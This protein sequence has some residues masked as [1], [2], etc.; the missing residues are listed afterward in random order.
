MSTG[1]QRLP[2]D[3]AGLGPAAGLA[4]AALVA[5]CLWKAGEAGAQDAKIMAYGRHLAQ[6]CTGCHRID[7][8]DNGI[9]SITGWQADAFIAT[10]RFY[11]RGE[12]KNPVMVSVANSLNEKQLEA[13]AT[14][15]GSLPKPAPKGKRPGR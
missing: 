14:Y 12:R 7:G 2:R 13:L 3:P 6:E 10:V 1:K 5:L 4:G 8:I 11:Q 15:F 9:P